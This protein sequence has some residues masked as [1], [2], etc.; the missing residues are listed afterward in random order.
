MST[1]II[2]LPDFR[3]K[4]SKAILT[5]STPITLYE[6]FST[7]IQFDQILKNVNTEKHQ[8][9]HGQKIITKIAMALWF[10]GAMSAL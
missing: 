6:N 9:L 5:N 2:C 10:S 3:A 1:A 4:T 7:S 8:L